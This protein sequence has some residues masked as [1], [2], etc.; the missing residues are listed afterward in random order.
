MI[1]PAHSFL[2]LL[3]ASSLTFEVYRRD[4]K[5]RAA[6]RAL[7][8]LLAG[9]PVHSA[10]RDP[11]TSINKSSPKLSQVALLHHWTPITPAFVCILLHYFV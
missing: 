11:H 9:A 7:P 5:W 3:S 1:G 6:G 10:D 4:E 2:S 8:S